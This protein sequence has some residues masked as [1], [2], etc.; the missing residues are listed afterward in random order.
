MV[1]PLLGALVGAGGSI[2]SGIIGA[3]AADTAAQYNWAANLLNY[4][5]RERER[6]EAIRQ[7]NQTRHDNKLGITDAQGTRT[8]FVEGIGWVVD[9]APDVSQMRDLQDA[10]QRQVL[11]HD[12]PQRRAGMDRN[13]KRS[14]QEEALADMF[15]RQMGNVQRDDDRVYED[16]IYQAATQGINDA[17]DRSA[18]LAL[19][20]AMRTGGSNSNIGRTV[21]ALST[22]R[23]DALAKAAADARLKSLGMGQSQFEKERGGLANLYN[24][25]AA[26]A[27]ALPDVSYR[28]QPVSTE[29]N[30]NVGGLSASDIRTG[31][32]AQQAYG[33]KGGTL[34]YIQP[35]YGWANAVGGGA[36]ALASALRTA[37]VSGFGGQSGQS[38]GFSTRMKNEDRY[39][40]NE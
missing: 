37:G 27:A 35:N 33:A 1:L 3:G 34:D 13:Y 32:L 39:V 26:R 11:T 25:F 40:E 15:R 17:S 22:T 21:E 9:E 4:Y 23:N 18:S 14:L 2:A 7:A 38:G 36:S 30:Q 31:A 10:E 8:H 6:E 24:M 19:T 12:L 29:A 16:A 28:P 5:Q 20:H